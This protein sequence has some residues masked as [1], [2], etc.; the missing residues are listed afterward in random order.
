MELCMNLKKLF[1]CAAAVAG[2]AL[3]ACSDDSSSAAPKNEGAEIPEE[4][5]IEV[6]SAIYNGIG[7]WKKFAEQ[8]VPEYFDS[9]T[10]ANGGQSPIETAL[11]MNGRCAS[12]A[13]AMDDGTLYLDEMESLFREGHLVKGVCG[14]ATSLKSGQVA[15]LG[16]NL[17]D[18]M[19][20]GT[21]E[22]WFRPGEDFYEESSRT[23]LGN[24][25]SRLHFFVRNGRLIFQKN[26]AD[27]HFLVSGRVQLKN[28]WNKIAGQWGDG[29]LSLWLNDSLVA[30]VEH[31]KGYA[32]S[33]RSKPF[34]N[35]LVVGF[36]SSC[37]MELADQYEGMTT[38][39]DY[40]QVRISKVA[41]YKNPA[42]EVEPESSSSELEAESSSSEV[43]EEISSS[44]VEIAKDTLSEAKD[45]DCTKLDCVA[46][47]SNSDE[48]FLS[49]T[50]EDFIELPWLLNSTIP[51]GA[52][53]FTF[54]A[55]ENFKNESAR[56]L[57]GT[58][59]G[60]L[61]FYYVNGKLKFA[62][63]GDDVFYEVGAE[64]DFDDWTEIVAQWGY[65]FIALYVN[66]VKV[67][68]LELDDFQYMPSHRQG[69]SNRVVTG[70]KT[71][72]CMA[73]I[74]KDLTTEGYFKKISITP[75]VYDVE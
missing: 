69:K 4:P 11:R 2:L 63:N 40:D 17:L 72:C 7:L 35:L 44:S 51:Q 41:R 10:V 48:G 37:C 45:S 49:V 8:G 54:K 39:G 67:D 52:F 58:D 33:L 22:F 36:K 13:M 56:F 65:E 16:I 23:L 50:S 53:S 27:Q 20:V 68:S 43:A 42:V 15:P 5:S 32:P 31:D 1:S 14:Y 66:G 62:K 55:N 46:D 26:H 57:V 12:P 9:V 70:Q 6:D 34:G 47:Y 21:V 24:D 19:A 74:K 71:Y 28:D 3:V 38:S 73:S 64:V 75:W 25:E 60:R 61:T 29:Y 18:S 30:R 59:E